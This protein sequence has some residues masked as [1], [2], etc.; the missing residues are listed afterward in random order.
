METM[1]KLAAVGAVVAS[2]LISPFFLGIPSPAQ[3]S[4]STWA[5]GDYWDYVGTAMLGAEPANMTLKIK[6][7]ERSQIAVGR[8]SYD[9]YHCLLWANVTA[10]RQ[11][12]FVQGNSIYYRTSDLALVQ[13]GNAGPNPS[14]ITFDPPID[15]VRFPLESN[16]TWSV[17][18]DA[19][20]YQGLSRSNTTNAFRFLVSSRETIA[21]PAGTFEAFR[22]EKLWPMSQY[23]ISTAS[24]SDQVGFAVRLSNISLT[25]DQF[26]RGYGLPSTAGLRAYSHGA[27]RPPGLEVGGLESGLFIAA[28]ATAVGIVAGVAVLF[29]RRRKIRT[30]VPSEP[31]PGDAPPSRPPRH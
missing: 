18:T 10:P 29:L 12:L 25:N 6:V 16:Q 30:D 8:F 4:A 28:V 19:A 23:V 26:Y 1:S 9:T 14:Y 13:Y 2:V 7:M 20:L 15:W 17:T 5:P 31:A 22:V 21:V 27:S 3:G 11:S 24:Y